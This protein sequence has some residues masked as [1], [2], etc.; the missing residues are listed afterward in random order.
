[1]PRTFLQRLTILLMLAACIAAATPGRVIHREQSPFNPIIVRENQRGIRTMHFREDGLAQTEID[2]RNPR[3]LVSAYARVSMLSLAIVPRPGRILVVG[4]GGGAMPTF[5]RHNLPEALI[6]IAELDPQVVTV[7]ERFFFFRQDAKMTVHAGDGRT[8]IEKSNDR[9]DIIF[10]D[11]FGPDDA[12]YSLTT[13]EFLVLVQSHLAEGGLAAANVCGPGTNPLYHSMIKTYQDVFPELHIIRAPASDNQVVFAFAAG[14]GMTRQQLEKLASGLQT[15][16]DPPLNL[17]P[18]V[19][20]QYLR[21][22]RLPADARV[23][24]DADAPPRR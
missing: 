4:L 16:V 11:A 7:A 13:R 10:L 2:T 23:L 1:M 24:L 18:V 21:A 15:S 3:R 14:T 19:R 22:P 6:D 20:S 8:F 5:L 17:E 12:P 9:Y